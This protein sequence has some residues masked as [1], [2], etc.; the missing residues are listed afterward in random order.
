VFDAGVLMDHENGLGI[1]CEL[2]F[3]QR[4]QDMKSLMELDGSSVFFTLSDF[5]WHSSFLSCHKLLV[6]PISLS[7][8]S[9]Q[10]STKVT[11]L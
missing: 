3:G 5:S 7:L 11:L 4:L 8:A 2:N 6:I 9:P 10:V 1:I